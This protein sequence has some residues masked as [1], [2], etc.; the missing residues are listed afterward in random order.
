MYPAGYKCRGPWS[1]E[2]EASRQAS[3]ADGC[4]RRL[5]L[6]AVMHAPQRQP[7]VTPASPPGNGDVEWESLL[8]AAFGATCALI[9]W[10]II[11]ALTGVGKAPTLLFPIAI[12]AVLVGA[13]VGLT[14]AAI[15]LWVLSGLAVL[16]RSEER[17]VGKECR[18]R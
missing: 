11:G 6:I 4:R 7:I 9:G 15:V 1:R 17:R 16:M 12:L 10:L 8:M 13:V 2:A 3:A 14:R 5:Y 18:S